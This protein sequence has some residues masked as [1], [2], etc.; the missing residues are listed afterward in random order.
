MEFL[1]TLFNNFYFQSMFKII[2]VLFLA[3][4]IGLE[5]DSWNKPAGFRT[6]ALVGLSAVLVVIC[7]EY[8]Y[9]RYDADPSRIAAQLLSGIGFIG[10]GTILRDGFNVKGLTTAASLLA[11][12]CIGLCIGAGFYFI[13]IVATVILYIVLSYSYLFTDK[14][15]HF[16]TSELTIGISGSKQETIEHIQNILDEKDI[17]IKRLE[18]SSSIDDNDEVIET[19]KLII[20]Y[21][22]NIKISKII[23]TISNLEAVCSIEEN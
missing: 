23:N 1:E 16:L 19:V 8:M 17:T 10:A 18:K 7:G 22:H 3:G 5:R 11:V 21:N 14:L 6:H 20:R 15:D 4:A 13:G 12:T 9:L 2:L